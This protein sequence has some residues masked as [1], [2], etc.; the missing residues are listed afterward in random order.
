MTFHRSSSSSSSRRPRSLYC[1]AT[2]CAA[3]LSSSAR[4]LSSCF[5]R[6]N[7]GIFAAAVERVVVVVVVVAASAEAARAASSLAVSRSTSSSISSGF[8]SVAPGRAG[9]A[10]ASFDAH[11]AIDSASRDS[12]IVAI[13]SVPRFLPRLDSSRDVRTFG[14]ARS[15]RADD[16]GGDARGRAASDDS[17][18]S[19][20]TSVKTRTRLL[21]TSAAS[22]ALRAA[23]CASPGD[24]P[25]RRAGRRADLDATRSPQSF[26]AR[27]PP[28]PRGAH[29][30][31]PMHSGDH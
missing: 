25:V 13:A 17:A 16:D 12:V 22:R 5:G 27:P 20:R 24:A 19:G 8:R 3:D 15:R 14:F 2:L 30:A 4:K 31:Q 23:R 28:T 1:S 21:S 29:P 26:A 10:D 6:K 7:V 11:G 18:R 9:N